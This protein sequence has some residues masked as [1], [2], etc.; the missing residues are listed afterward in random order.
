MCKSCYLWIWNFQGVGG[1]NGKLMEI[2]GSGGEYYEAPWN[3]KSWGLKLEKNLLHG[4]G[5]WI[6]SGTT[7]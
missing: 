1:P 7:H 2:P 5:L 4:G 6:F 3:G